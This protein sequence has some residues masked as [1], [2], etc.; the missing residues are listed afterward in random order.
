M[1]QSI[2]FN[3]LSVQE[4]EFVG[5]IIELASELATYSFLGILDGTIQIEEEK[6]KGVIELLFE[7]DGKSIL[8]NDANDEDLCSIFKSIKD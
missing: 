1:N 3:Q 6:N 8:L 2:I 5:E 7:K 4:K